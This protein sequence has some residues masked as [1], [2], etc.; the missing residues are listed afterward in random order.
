MGGVL[1]GTQIAKLN[2][3]EKLSDLRDEI[4]EQLGIKPFKT[5]HWER[6]R[7]KFLLGSPDCNPNH[8]PKPRER[9]LR[10]RTFLGPPLPPAGS[11]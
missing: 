3:K 9:W 4:T 8:Q 11:G 10:P 5:S 1:A 2:D 7:D 6:K